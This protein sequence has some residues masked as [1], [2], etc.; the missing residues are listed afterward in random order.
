MRPRRIKPNSLWTLPIILTVLALLSLSRSGMPALLA[1]GAYV[2]ALGGGFAFGWFSTQHSELNLDPAT[3]TI[4]NKPTPLGTL[5]T[6]AVFVARFAVEYLV[7]GTP[8]GPPMP[9]IA[10][11]QA[12]SA[13]WL[14]NAGLFFVAA[15]MIGRAWHLWIRTRPLLAQ[16][17]AHRAAQAP[18]Q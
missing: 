3:G 18:P 12:A 1:L 14:A 10:P 2:V 7:K 9:H 16:L 4:T 11:Q 15:R 17:E 13:I 8:G 5:L 6:A